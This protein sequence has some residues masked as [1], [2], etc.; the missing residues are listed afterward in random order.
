MYC[1]ACGFALTEGF[2][3]CPQCG[4]PAVTTPASG[5]EANRPAP[6]L[7]RPRYD[8]K[9]AGVCAGIARYLGVD[10]TL[11]RILTAVL[12]LYP[13]CFGVLIYIVC[14]IVMPP[15]PVQLPPAPALANHI[16]KAE[17]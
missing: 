8:K 11:I 6:R 4:A 12:A 7:S 2:C 14:W 10:V 1:S 3:F 17:G 5:L 9:I 13:P 16:A 15:D